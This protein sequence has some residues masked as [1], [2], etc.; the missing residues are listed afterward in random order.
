[1]TLTVADILRDALLEV[2]AVEKNELPDP[3]E[4]Q[5]AMRKLNMM[6][7]LWAARR[8]LVR[9]VTKESFALT[10]GKYQ[11]TIGVGGNF[12]TGKPLRIVS[13][14]IRDTNNFDTDLEIISP[15]DYDSLEDKILS[16]A[17]PEYL[18]FDP[19]P[20][21]QTTQTGTIYIA[22]PPDV[23]YTLF[24]KEQKFFTEAA[25]GNDPWTFEPEY[26]EPIVTNLAVRL[27]RQYHDWNTG[28][29]LDL[30]ELAKDGLSALRTLNHVQL[31][32]ATDL[33]GSSRAY[34]IYTGGYG[35]G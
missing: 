32:A 23:A 6:L 19:G 28:V 29:P 15:Q 34:N 13:A 27:W 9:A 30:K 8:L 35:D 10:A 4:L 5:D 1:M 22:S 20:A 14:F 24:I 26:S 21:Q 25:A 16:T 31:T 12:N 11:Y 18:A 17:R 7:N 2:G 3:D 33:P